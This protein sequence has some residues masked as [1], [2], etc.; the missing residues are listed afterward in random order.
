MNDRFISVDWGTSN[1]RARLAGRPGGDILAQ[2]ASDDGVARLAAEHS[3]AERPAAFRR[4]L[5]GAVE[6]LSAECRRD[7]NGLPVV[8]S[9]MAS[10]TLGWQELEYARLPFALDG[11]SLVCQRLPPLGPAAGSAPVLLLSG[12]RSANDIM[13]GEETEALGLQ[14][15]LSTRAQTRDQYGPAVWIFPG[16]HSK[17][18][19]VEGRSIVDFATFMTGE[20]F[21]VLCSSSVLRH[22]TQTAGGA[23]SPAPDTSGDFHAGLEEARS[24]PLTGALFHVRT[25]AVLQGT[26]GP[27]N[28]A[29]LSALLIGAEIAA[30]NRRYPGVQ[31]IVLCAAGRLAEPYERAL[32]YFGLAQ[33]TTIVPADVVA[34]LSVRGQCVAL[35]HWLPG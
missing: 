3:P 16:T 14:H 35:E 30:V 25:R 6:R 5:L 21:D 29:F 13:R 28:A 11:S 12:V 2:I 18:L 34:T 24:L 26:S 1:L 27:A 22:A 23:M 15:Y 4:T 17:H 19:L 8:I 31:H 9:G 20:L 32:A 33:R 7:L 10:S